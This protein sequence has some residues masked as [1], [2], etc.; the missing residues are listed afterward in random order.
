MAP[1]TDLLPT[2]PLYSRTRKKKRAKQARGKLG[3]GEGGYE[4]SKPEYVTGQNHDQ[5]CHGDDTFVPF[6]PMGFFRFRRNGET[7]KRGI[8]FLP[9]MSTAPVFLL[10]P[11]PFPV[12]SSVL[13]WRPVVSRFHPRVQIRENRGL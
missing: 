6:Q 5:H 13:R 4:R 2:H 10:V 9:K 11:T 3:G 8:N 7:A 12:K 1:D